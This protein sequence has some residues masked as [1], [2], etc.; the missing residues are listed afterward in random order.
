MDKK[1]RVLIADDVE[2][3]RKNIRTLLEFEDKIEVVGEAADGDEALRFTDELKPDLVLMDINM[4]KIDG[5]RATEKINLRHPN[6]VVV[7]M[8][9]QGEQEYLRRAM[10]SGAK[11]Y[12]VKPF[13]LETLINTITAAYVKEQE[14]KHFV[15]E[16]KRKTVKKKDPKTVTVFSTKGG[17]GKS[18]ITINTAIS[19]AKETGDNV[20]ILDLDLYFGDISVMLNIAPTKTIVDVI[21]EIGHLTNDILDEYMIEYM[22]G[23][24]VLPSPFKPE[25]AEY[26]LPSHIEKII[27]VLKEDYQYIII[28]SVAGFSEVMLTALDKSDQ[29]IMLSTMN[30][31]T[32]KNVKLG[33]DVMA[34]LQYPEEKTKIVV[35][36]VSK[37][38]GITMTDIEE[39]L[40]REV[41]MCIP[42]DS[43]TVIQAANKGYPFMRSRGENKISNS[44]KAITNMIVSGSTP[45]T[46]KR[47]V[48]KLLS[49][50]GLGFGSS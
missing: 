21:E 50:T 38:Y 40:N 16:E 25:Y 10:L 5:L 36:R 17:V 45:K 24:K 35:N 26:I 46:K 48:N 28:D 31:A 7:M 6:I 32:L 49:K 8:S 47:L 2:D 15:A 27:D 42:E 39:V 3:T 11:D 23:V 43:K 4:P 33:L 1:I 30:L 14:R 13:S 37:H 29:I 22:R 41:N 34:S 19:L 9:V 12:L 20:A 44:I 18:T